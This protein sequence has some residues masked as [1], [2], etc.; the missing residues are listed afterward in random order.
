METYNVWTQRPPIKD[1][2]EFVA[3]LRFAGLVQ[4]ENGSDAIREAKRKNMS[5]APIVAVKQ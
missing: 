2:D 4:A 5:L 1:G 3:N